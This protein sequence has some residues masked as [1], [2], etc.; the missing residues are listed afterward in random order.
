MN[1]RSGE[2]GFEVDS[3]ESEKWMKASAN[4]GYAPAQHNI[5][6]LYE[7][8]WRRT[9]VG[10]DKAVSWYKKAAEQGY[11]PSIEKLEELQNEFPELF[12]MFENS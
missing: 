1:Y 2:N 4:N 10:F 8:S 7:Q 9:H 3:Y 11:K 6:L 12:K 5:G